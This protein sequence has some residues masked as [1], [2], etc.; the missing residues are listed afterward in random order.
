MKT[1]VRDRTRLA[2]WLCAGMLLICLLALGHYL[3]PQPAEPS[4]AAF[5]MV[6]IDIA[7]EETANFYHVQD[8]GVYVLAV[9]EK[10]PAEQAGVSSGDLLLNVNAAPICN[11]GEWIA[12]QETF[13]PGE[14]VTMDFQRGADRNTYTVRLV[15]NE[16]AEE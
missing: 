5:G 4:G 1:Q 8:C 15:W 13:V 9:Q 12:L 7:D 16:E 10:S 6:L 14:T 11:T 2:V 3:S